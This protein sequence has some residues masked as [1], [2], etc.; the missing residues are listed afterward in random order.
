M[1][2]HAVRDSFNQDRPLLSDNQLTCLF[3]CPV[4]GKEIIAVDSNSGH[5]VSDATGSDTI[6]RVLVINGRR[7]SVHVVTAVEQ[8]LAAQGGGEVQSWVEVTLR[9]GTFAEISHS[10]AIVATDTEVVAGA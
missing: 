5:A 6:A 2:T 10:D 4:D 3:S 8:G 1:V 7:D 9:S